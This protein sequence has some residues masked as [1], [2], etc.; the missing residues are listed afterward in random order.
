M[1]LGI[2]VHW[3]QHPYILLINFGIDWQCVWNINDFLLSSQ[4]PASDFSLDFGG[5]KLYQKD[6]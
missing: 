3:V 4:L 2:S 1:N 6:K 5:S